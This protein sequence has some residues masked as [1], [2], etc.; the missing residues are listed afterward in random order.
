[1]E[2]TEKLSREIEILNQKLDEIGNQNRFMVFT[3]KRRKF[4]MYNFLAGMWYSLGMLFGTAVVAT[5]AVYFLSK[6]DF[7]R[8]ISSWVQSTLSQIKWE[9]II[10][11]PNSDINLQLNSNPNSNQKA[12]EI[13]VIETATSSSN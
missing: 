1:M 12:V 11:I 6:I 10:G 2:P 3:T 7:T 8:S 13:E 4:A 9:K 5:V